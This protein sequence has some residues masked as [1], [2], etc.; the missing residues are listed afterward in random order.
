ML[1]QIKSVLL[2]IYL[3]FQVFYFRMYVG[4]VILGALHGLLLLHVLLSYVG[5]AP[6]KIPPTATSSDH[7][8]VSERTPLIKA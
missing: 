3:F 4:I 6:R 5:S 7:T 1:N 8:A 2:F